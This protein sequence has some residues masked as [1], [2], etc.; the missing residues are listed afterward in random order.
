MMS[1]LTT[2]FST[3]YGYTIVIVPACRYS[4]LGTAIVPRNVLVVQL[5]LYLKVLVNLRL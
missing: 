3:F 1:E 5:Q 4:I 2:K